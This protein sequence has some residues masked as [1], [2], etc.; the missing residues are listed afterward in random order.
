MGTGHEYTNVQ[1][2]A[3][4]YGIN[5]SKPGYRNVAGAGTPVGRNPVLLELSDKRT[6][7]AASA[8]GNVAKTVHVWVTCERL[9]SIVGGKVMVS[10]S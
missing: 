3:H 9:M 7:A 2:N 10:G 4:Y 5:L 8:S 1:G 6:T